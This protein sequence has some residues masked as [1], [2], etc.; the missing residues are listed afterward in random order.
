MK[1]FPQHIKTRIVDYLKEGLS[2]RDV[3]KRV[4]S[5]SH[6][7]VSRILNTETGLPRAR[8]GRPYKLSDHTNWKVIRDILSGKIENA[9]IAAHEHYS[10]TFKHGGGSLMFWGCMTWNGVGQACKVEGGQWIVRCIVKF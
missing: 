1:I 3:A 10:C 9:V 4:P 5:V 7:T 6:M 8:A 2:C